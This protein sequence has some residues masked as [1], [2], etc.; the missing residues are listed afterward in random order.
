MSD[1]NRSKNRR[2]I[3]VTNWGYQVRYLWFH[4]LIEVLALVAVVFLLF[5][6]LTAR[7]TEDKVYHDA[8]SRD[9]I[10]QIYVLVLL[11]A[12]FVVYRSLLRSHQIAGPFVRIRKDY[13]RMKQGDLS[14]D[15]YLRKKDRLQKL[16]ADHRSMKQALRDLIR[17]DRD[18][19][20]QAQNAL[21][22]LQTTVRKAGLSEDE[23]QEIVRQISIIAQQMESI[24]KRFILTQQ[25]D[26]DSTR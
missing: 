17:A 8:W 21:Q 20:A 1:S 13:E 7:L 2:R 12:V 9:L 23:Q 25:E 4:D 26:Q 19:A 15:L 5:F 24:G 18:A 6:L 3:L 16:A 14:F 10:Q 11:L 22:T